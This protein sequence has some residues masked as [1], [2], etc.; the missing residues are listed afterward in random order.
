MAT[1]GSLSQIANY[2]T[3]G[4]W[5]DVG[6]AR[7]WNLGSNWNGSVYDASAQNGEITYK[8][9]TLTVIGTSRTL[10]V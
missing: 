9:N 6:R 7:K 4:F 8:V 5:Q 3:T 10:M 2:L 1:T